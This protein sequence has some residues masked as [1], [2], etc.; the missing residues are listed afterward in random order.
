MEQLIV[1][2]GSEP[3]SPVFWIVWSETEQEIIASGEL[4]N[5]QELATLKERAGERPVTALAPS[6][7]VL[8]KWVTLPPRA[9]R[10]VINAIPF[11][12]EDELST[13]VTEQFFAMGP[14]SGNQQAVAIVKHAQIKFWM[15]ALEDAG[16][17]C[18]KIV[19]DVLALPTNPEGWSLLAVGNEWLIRQDQWSGMQGEPDWLLPGIVHFAKQQE[20]P[21]VIHDYTGIETSQLANIDWQ[22]QT[23]EM[24]MHVLVKG[25]QNATFNL[26]QGEYKVKKKTNETWRQWRV[27]AILACVALTLSVADKAITLSSL[28][29]QYDSLVQQTNDEIKRGFPEIRVIRDVR[30]M[31]NKRLTELEQGGTGVS[32]LAMLEQLGTAF[33]QTQ[34][35]P[36]A[37]RY[38]SQRKELR[39][40]AAASNFT[41]LE[42]FSNQAEQSGFSVEQGAIN[43]RDNQV[44]GS[45]IIKG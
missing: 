27:A 40:Q 22:V 34:V 32:V 8:L 37:L 4:P 10:K 6:S 2:L 16:L 45:I 41:A 24:P 1:R 5:A 44:I 7:D 9:G 17:Y 35:K 33:S 11:M 14:K 15:S 25:T 21:L 30:R 19:P 28:N 3:S 12:L 29:S 31:L 20:D 18:D 26:L 23:L 36:Q 39:L 38:D 42:R 43:N 13:D